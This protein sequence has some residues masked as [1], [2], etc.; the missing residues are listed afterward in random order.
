M[1]LPEGRSLL[2]VAAGSIAVEAV[3]VDSSLD[4][5]VVAVRKAVVEGDSHLAEDTAVL[6]YASASMMHQA[7]VLR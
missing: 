6:L 7:A 4:S 1:S 2:G 5:S 3:A